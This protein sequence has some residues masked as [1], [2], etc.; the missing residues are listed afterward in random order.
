MLIRSPEH[1]IKS[2]FLCNTLKVS[3]IE[4]GLLS[5]EFCSR[6][7]FEGSEKSSK[8]EIVDC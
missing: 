4:M 2:Q 1:T 8:I 3:T 6:D 5:V 7:E